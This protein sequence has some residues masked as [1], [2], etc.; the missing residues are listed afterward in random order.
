MKV[1]LICLHVSL[2]LTHTW[3]AQ[4]HSTI[5]GKVA[6]ENDVP[7]IF[8]SLFLLQK[9]DSTLVTT[10]L[11]DSSGRYYLTAGP[12]NYLLRISFAGYQDVFHNILLS[13][14]QSA[15]EMPIT[16]LRIAEK[17]LEAV[18][19]TAQKPL[20][21]HKI[22]RLVVNV[23]SSALS[24]AA[25]A[26]EI[27]QKLPGVVIV[28]DRIS[29]SGKTGVSILIN[30]KPSPYADMETVLKDLPG[31]AI[32]R[33]ELMHTPGARF[34]ASGQAG[35]INLVLKKNLRA[36]FNGSVQLGGGLSHYNQSNVRSSDKN[37][38]RFT[39]SANLN[40]RSG[41]WNIFGGLDHLRRSVFEVNNLDR[42]IGH[43]LYKQTNYYPYQYNT[44][45]YRLGID[46]SLGKKT[47]LGFLWNGY[48]RNGEGTG[49][50]YTDIIQA[51]SGI[52]SDSFQTGNTTNINRTSTSFNL[53]F[54]HRFDSMGK[55]LNIDLDYSD[56]YYRTIGDMQIVTST[57]ETILQYQKGRTPL[58]YWTAKADYEHPFGKKMKLEMGFKRSS[59]TVR[60]QLSFLR[61]KVYD[62]SRSNNF[63][64]KESILAA[65]ASMGGTVR[66]LQWQLGLRTERTANTGFLADSLALERVYWQLFPSLFLQQEISK[67]LS[68]HFTYSRRLDR[69]DFQLLS[70][71][72]YFIDSLTYAQGNPGL[73][74]QLSHTARFTI[75]PKRWPSLSLA[76]S[77]VNQVIYRE[78]PYQ[79][80]NITYTLAENLGDFQNLTAELNYSFQPVN[81]LSGYAGLLFFHSF[82][83]TAFADSAYRAGKWNSQAYGGI[84]YAFT[85]KFSAELNFFYSSGQ[86][87]EFT[88][89]GAS[90][91][92]NLGIQ[93]TVWKGKGK[94][95]ATINDIFYQNPTN[96]TVQYGNINTRYYYRDDSRNARISFYYSFGKHAVRKNRDRQTGS[97]EE[98]NRL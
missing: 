82:Y 6:L 54:N 37:Y 59:V 52:R 12:G 88:V 32:E 58:H 87:N 63:L 8:A 25:S 57:N 1:F 90:S 92:I 15:V 66:K 71:F 69:P 89:V 93:Q 39:G 60:N 36:G 45:T 70:P 73:L 2:F 91:G 20:L 41:N 53:N 42:I 26:W 67:R 75:K 16:R 51:H 79:I 55:L 68:F 85:P 64:Y 5:S 4:A 80:G 28:N 23:S 13:A 31:N 48:H 35:I 30:G 33:V 86:L 62:S 44:Y 27:M 97:A 21:E 83:K 17:Q 47:V 11:T 29:L 61:N 9:T 96:S 50:T 14:D 46:Y 56:Y 10:S 81:K 24:A 65:Y 40:Y 7:A 19:V 94:I 74:P 3:F 78:A 72:A 84:S 95:S 34:D 18:V 43:T 38:H 22:D 76:Y 98:Q 77:Y 49:R